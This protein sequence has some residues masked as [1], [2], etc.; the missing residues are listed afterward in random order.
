MDA[1]AFLT[2]PG[3]QDLTRS[4]Q[5]RRCGRCQATRKQGGIRMQTWSDPA[6]TQEYMDF[7]TG[8]NQRE[9]KRDC[10]STIVGRGRLGNFLFSRGDGTDLVIG[11][12]ETI[13]EDAPAGPIYLCTRNDELQSI[14][15]GC[16]ESRRDDLVFVLDA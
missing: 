5:R 12:D 13:P 15:E 3:I 4:F 11:R 10:R 6:V 14:V 2:S 7:L 16:P 8:E 1:I 9:M